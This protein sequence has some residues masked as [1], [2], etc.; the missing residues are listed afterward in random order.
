MVT[1][2]LSGTAE[3]AN[4]RRADSL[5]REIF[6]DVANKWA[7]LIIE[8]LGEGTLRFS[9]LRGRV[10][11]I[12]HKMLTQNLRMLERNGLAEREVH[13]TVPPRVEYTL[14]EAGHG[15]RATVDGMCEWTYRYF[16]HIETARQ[17]FEA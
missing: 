8:A 11:G 16:R 1:K 4:L 9:E 17:R 7:L 6:S 10:E 13:P 2:Q 12:S 15:L 14:T 3:D 5:G